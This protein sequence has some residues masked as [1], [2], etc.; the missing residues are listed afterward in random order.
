M[1]LSLDPK[2]Q[3][4]NSASNEAKLASLR[5]WIGVVNNSP[6]YGALTQKIVA[7][8]TLKFTDTERLV[9]SG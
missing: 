6:A 5:S 4:A 2:Q 7:V 9:L 3:I 8:D 1:A